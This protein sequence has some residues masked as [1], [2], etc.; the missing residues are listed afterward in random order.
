MAA[1]FPVNDLA[2]A[3]AKASRSH[4]VRWVVSTAFR[5]FH[6]SFPRRQESQF[7]AGQLGNLGP[8]FRRDERIGE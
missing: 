4:Y 1:I 8:G 6:R 7:A 2:P 5:G 3:L